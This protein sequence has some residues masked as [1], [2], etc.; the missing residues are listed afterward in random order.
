MKLNKKHVL[1]LLIALS[2]ILSIFV[3]L[4]I[5][6]SGNIGNNDLGINVNVDGDSNNDN[7]GNTGN[8]DVKPNTSQNQNLNSNGLNAN[9]VFPYIIKDTGLVIN[10]IQS[11]NGDYFEDG[12]NSSVN[13]VATM[14]LTNTGSS[15]IEYGEIYVKSGN[16]NLT[17]VV[18][19]LP[20]GKSVVVQE[21]NKKTFKNQG[22]I[23]C[24][25]TV[26][27]VDKFAKNEDTIK[28]EET[29]KGAIRVTNISD[30]DIPTV[31]VFYKYYMEDEDIYVGGITF[32][33]M[34]SDLKKNET[35]EIYPKHYVSEYS[36][37]LMVRVYEE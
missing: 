6:D 10:K 32:T 30:K 8:S 24:S 28:I 26:V 4:V 37:I 21:K 7:D 15:N 35:Q 19:G 33:A 11:Y 2:L 16:E 14:V 23:E 9:N 5:N 18:S 36:E 22:N 29:N 1:I 17:F 13:S 3:V 20:K 25:A 12:S 31:R 27:P 34:V